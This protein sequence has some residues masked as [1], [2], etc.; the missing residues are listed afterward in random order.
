MSS[1]SRNTIGLRLHLD[2]VEGFTGFL[3]GNTFG[4]PFFNLRYEFKSGRYNFST[5]PK[6]SI[7]TKKIFFSEV[8]N[9]YFEE[10]LHSQLPIFFQREIYPVLQTFVKHKEKLGWLNGNT[11]WSR[12]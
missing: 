7:Y 9:P 5:F 4:F 11:I 2:Y 3:L 12:E 10:S 6:N 1:N 8:L